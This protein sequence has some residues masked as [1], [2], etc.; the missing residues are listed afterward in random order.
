MCDVVS[1]VCWAAEAPMPTLE[2]AF[3]ARFGFFDYSVDHSFVVVRLER[4]RFVSEGDVISDEKNSYSTEN[5]F[6]YFLI[7]L[8]TLYMSIV[9]SC[10]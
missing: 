10:E 1:T 9:V 2:H 6:F 3:S 7:R 5:E 8:N 4:A